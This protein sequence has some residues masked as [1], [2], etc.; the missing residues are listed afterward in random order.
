LTE[1]IFGLIGYTILEKD[2][3]KVL[4]MADRHD[5]LPPCNY[6]YVSV[7]EWMK[8][9]FNTSDILLEEVERSPDHTLKELWDTSIHTQELKNLYLN[10][11][12]IVVPIDIRNDYIPYSWEIFNK[13]DK[14][15]DIT[16]GQYLQNINTFFTLKCEKLKKQLNIYNTNLLRKTSLGRYYLMLKKEYRKFID[17]NRNYLAQKMKNVNRHKIFNT[18]N[19]ILHGILEWYSIAR[20]VNSNK[21]SII[22]TGLAHSEKI[23][24]HLQ[25]LFGYKIIN[26][27]GTNTMDQLNQTGISCFALPTDLN[28]QFGGNKNFGIFY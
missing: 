8:T 28:K 16:V 22:H 13:D 3:K 4:V 2:G 14:D 15:H 11:T 5:E 26:S 18:F 10:N 6:D 20:I 1:Q 24:E 23:V 7:A 9:K 19:D 21:N 25:K 12:N 27:Q 17:T